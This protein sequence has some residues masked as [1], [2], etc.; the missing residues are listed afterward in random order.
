M[1]RL[2]FVFLLLLGCSHLNRPKKSLSINLLQEP[3]SV[4]PRFYN[5]LTLN[6]IH[7]MLYR[8]LFK[9]DEKGLIQKD[10]VD[11]Y[12]VSS[13]KKSYRLILKKAYWS[14]GSLITAKE[15]EQSYKQA[16]DPNFP[17]KYAYLFYSIKNAKQ[18]IEQKVLPSAL[19]IQAIDEKTLQI[20]LEKPD[21]HFLHKLT[22][23]VY[24]PFK[25]KVFSGP[26]QIETWKLKDCMIL[27][28]NPFYGGKIY[29]DTIHI[30]FISSESVAL[31]L[32]LKK[33]LDMIGF[34]MTPIPIS[35]S[36]FLKDQF[37]SKIA[38]IYGT[39]ILTL[40]HHFLF[41]SLSLKKALLHSIQKQEIVEKITHQGERIAH[42]LT[43]KTLSKTDY[44]ETKAKAYLD[45]NNLL[46]PLSL[47]YT[48]GEVN[49][50]I[51]QQL[52]HHWESVLGIHIKLEKHELPLLQ[53]RLQKKDYDI[54]LISWVGEY[55]SSINFLD[56]LSKKDH[57]KNE[58][59][60]ENQEYQTLLEDQHYLQA[61]QILE[62]EIPII[63]LYH[64]SFKIYFQKDLQNIQISPTGIIFFENLKRA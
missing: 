20:Q 8:P 56:R 57:F 31:N 23:C 63:P 33:K 24:L 49:H 43:P 18:I 45:K 48:E 14:D 55:P 36:K 2:F 10:L 29:F 5:E 15:I 50:L 16:L 44:D 39:K 53:E 25:E 21:P 61:E 32:F 30:S 40:N 4:D 41:Q 13:D 22:T 19:G 9:L 46:R 35:S 59:G 37:P 52:K 27:R 26:Y 42:T 11:H 12:V 51:A 3:V 47:I 7:Y 54:G 58:T 62:D 38:P 60:W 17:S 6:Q 28:K 1:Y 64:W 34:P